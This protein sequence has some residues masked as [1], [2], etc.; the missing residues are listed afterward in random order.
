MPKQITITKGPAVVG[1]GTEA[2]FRLVCLLALGVGNLGFP[3]AALIDRFNARWEEL[4][5]PQRV[6]LG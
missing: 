4:G 6:S 3:L 2:Q 5:R 1:T